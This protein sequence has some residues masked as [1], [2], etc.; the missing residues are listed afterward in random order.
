VVDIP[1]DA[2]VV[3]YGESMKAPA[4]AL[5]SFKHSLAHGGEYAISVNCIPGL[6]PDEIA[7]RGRRPNKR[8]CFTTAGAI[9][10]AGFTFSGENA[11]DGHMNIILPAPPS[12]D[13]LD[14]LA[15]C[16]TGSGANPNPVSPEDR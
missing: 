10:A 15:A 12:S 4:L 1:D 8:Y 11:P 14:K 13:D 6:A 7:A 3:R 9:R 5:A 16:F 2:F